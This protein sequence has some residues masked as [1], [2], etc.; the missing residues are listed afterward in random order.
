MSFPGNLS[1]GLNKLLFKALLYN[2]DFFLWSLLI[3]AFDQVSVSYYQKCSK[4]IIY[5]CTDIKANYFP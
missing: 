1:S 5:L 2:S 3:F 4:Q